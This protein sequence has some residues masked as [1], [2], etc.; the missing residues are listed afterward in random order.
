MKQI[1]LLN[2]PPRCG[3][4]TIGAA[5]GFPLIKFAAPLRAAA[6]AVFAIKDDSDYEAR[7][8]ARDPL[9]DISIRQ[10]MINMSE[11]FMKPS[12]SD[13]VFAKVAIKAIEDAHG[14]VV[15]TDC[16]F[17]CEMDVMAQHFGKDNVCLV[18][19]QRHDCTFNHDS[20]SYLKG[21][22]CHVIDLENSG[23][24]GDTVNRLRT[25]LRFAFKYDLLE[26]QP[27]A[28]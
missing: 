16:G 23:Y 14:T 1:I 13:D 5:L 28:M 7:K 11:R 8:D 17:Q 21:N 6:N 12:I 27:W 9:L 22:G 3:K 15:I 10:F 18:R 4:D 20:R 19:I 25:H 26:G 2:G 24:L